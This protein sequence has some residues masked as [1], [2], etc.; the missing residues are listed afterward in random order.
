MSDFQKV[1]LSVKDGRDVHFMGR[2]TVEFSTQ[3][4][5]GTKARW[6]EIRR[7][8]T[9]GGNIVIELSGMSDN[10]GERDVNQATV[11]GQTPPP[12]N[13]EVQQAMDFLKWSPAAKAFAKE[14]GWD[15]V[16]RV[17]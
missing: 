17:P 8:Q 13:A 3:N 9:E 2:P 12:L 11:I 14:A 6:Q 15:I 10:E 7:W 5:R 16:W 4:A 1:R